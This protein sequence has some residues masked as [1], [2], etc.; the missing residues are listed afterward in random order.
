MVIK[1]DHIQEKEQFIIGFLVSSC[2]EA[3]NLADMRSSHDNHSVLY[4]LKVICED[5][6]INLALHVLKIPFKLQT[7]AI[8]ILVGASQVV[9]ARD[10]YNRVFGSRNEGGYPQG[11]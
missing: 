3:I 5:R 8:Y 1:K 6:A 4:G 7:K 10:R 2:P 9:D 11:L